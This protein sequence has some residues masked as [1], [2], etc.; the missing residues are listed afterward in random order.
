MTKSKVFSGQDDIMIQDGT[1]TEC[2]GP[3]AL[4]QQFT[5]EQ[6]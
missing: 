4:K 3:S 5:S 6:R 2:T 1:V